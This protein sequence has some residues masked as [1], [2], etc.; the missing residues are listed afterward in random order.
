[1]S[2]GWSLLYDADC[3]FCRVCVA[4]LLVK[5]RHHRMEPVALQDPRAVALLPGLDEAARMAS[6][7]LVAPDGRVWS[8]GTRIGPGAAAAAGRRLRG[9]GRGAIPGCGG[10]RLLVRGAA[11]RTAGEADPGTG[12]DVGVSSNHGHGTLRVKPTKA[13]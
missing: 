9:E 6:W 12:E 5:D 10:S 4:V 13:F 7:H 2:D 8:A 3:G 1:M 11:P